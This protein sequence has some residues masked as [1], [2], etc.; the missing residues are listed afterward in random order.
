LPGAAR[1]PADF[2]SPARIKNNY[3]IC[4]LD[5]NIKENKLNQTHSAAR[6]DKQEGACP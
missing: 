6:A 3:T 4:G 1:V 5:K 2:E